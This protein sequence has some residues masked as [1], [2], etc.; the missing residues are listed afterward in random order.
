MKPADPQ[1]LGKHSTRWSIIHKVFQ[2]S[3]YWDPDVEIQNL[4]LTF[5]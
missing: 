4:H 2:G 1:D 5:H 3:L